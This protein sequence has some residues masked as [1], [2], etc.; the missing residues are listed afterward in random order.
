[1]TRIPGY[2][3]GS[4]K[5]A[6]VVGGFDLYVFVLYISS[7]DVYSSGAPQAVYEPGVNEPATPVRSIF[8]TMVPQF[9]ESKYGVL[10]VRSQDTLPAW[11]IACSFGGSSTV[12]TILTPVSFSNG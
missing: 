12:V 1:M 11:T 3:C 9:L 6:Q 2:F 5:S 10:S 4:K 8:C 7:I